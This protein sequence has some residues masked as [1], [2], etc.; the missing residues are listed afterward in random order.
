MSGRVPTTCSSAA[1]SDSHP[2]IL[3]RGRRVRSFG[4][5]LA[6]AS[7]QSGTSPSASARSSPV[8]EIV[9]SLIPSPLQQAAT[10]QGAPSSAPPMAS[11]SG[12]RSA[13]LPIG[14]FLEDV[15]MASTP[16]PNLDEDVTMES[17]TTRELAAA[18]KVIASHL[19]IPRYDAEQA[20]DKSKTKIN[21]V[22]SH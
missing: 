7:P 2:P 11:T 20:I 5:A 9:T 15:D 3:T 12:A 21:A 10:S 16:V 19:P 6:G 18:L 4:A 13:S 1:V 17:A 22:S 14:G 8:P